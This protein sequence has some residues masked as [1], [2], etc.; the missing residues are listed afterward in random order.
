MLKL[1]VAL[2]PRLREDT[3]TDVG[4]VLSNYDTDPWE[5]ETRIRLQRETI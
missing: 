1:E 4:Q 3:L 2:Y 5:E